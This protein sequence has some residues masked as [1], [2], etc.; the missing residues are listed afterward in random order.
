MQNREHKLPR[1]SKDHLPAGQGFHMFFEYTLV[2]NTP[3]LNKAR[4]KGRIVVPVSVNNAALSVPLKQYIDDLAAYEDAHLTQKK[5]KPR[6]FSRFTIALP[7]DFAEENVPE[8][9]NEVLALWGVTNETYFVRMH[10]KK[11]C[12]YMV[13][14]VSE[15]E[16]YPEEQLVCTYWTVDKYM[17]PK[18]GRRCQKD[19]PDAVL[20][21]KAGDVRSTENSHFSKKSGIF[22]LDRQTLKGRIAQT[23]TLLREF[24]LSHNT[25]S[26][27]GY[28]LPRYNYS[29]EFGYNKKS[30]M[31]A[32]N[33]MYN[34]MEKTLNRARKDLLDHNLVEYLPR[35]DAIVDG[36]R[37]DI[38]QTKAIIAG[39]H[40]NEDGKY[41][42]HVFI[43]FWRKF[44]HIIA[45]MEKYVSRFLTRVALI[46]LEAMKSIG[47]TVS[48]LW[49]DVLAEK[50]ESKIRKWFKY[51]IYL[52]LEGKEKARMPKDRRLSEKQ[53]NAMLESMGLVD[54]DFLCG[55]DT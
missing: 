53:R 25:R 12:R 27:Y 29:N 49:A 23:K 38:S 13:I 15:R 35:L 30:H 21:N 16:Y 54:H 47:Q 37:N 48:D 1:I 52:W 41:E 2:Q 36:I 24:C 34:G 43:E 19:A 32:L 45:E 42:G 26:G 31:K 10:R 46:M 39:D 55:A 18:T 33:T 11:K 5:N 17:D 8:L 28:L 50:R 40:F 44:K 20:C 51:H 3:G 9:A 6:Y 4:T 14:Y 7:V 22:K